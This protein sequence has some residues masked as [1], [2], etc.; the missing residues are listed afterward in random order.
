[1]TDGVDCQ[2]EKRESDETAGDEQGQNSAFDIARM[3]RAVFVNEKPWKCGW[4]INFLRLLWDYGTNSVAELDFAGTRFFM[5]L[6]TC[7]VKVTQEGI[8]ENLETS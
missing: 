3:S 7:Y 8:A 5:F 4:T 2:L 1:M 6:R